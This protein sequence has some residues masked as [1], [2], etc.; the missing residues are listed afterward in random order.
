MARELTR[1]QVL[2]LLAWGLASA[3]TKRAGAPVFEPNLRGRADQR[4]QIQ[5]AIDRCAASGG[6][7]VQLPAA[8]L[9]VSAEQYLKADGTVGGARSLALRSGVQLRGR[10]EKTVIRVAPHAY[11]P[12]ALF[13][14]IGNAESEPLESASVADLTLDGARTQQVANRQAGNIMLECKSHVT[15]ERVVSL[16]ANGTSI[17][18]RGTPERRAA[19]LAVR[20]CKVHFASYIGIQMSQFESGEIA[21]NEISDTDDNGI[22]I[23]GEDGSDVA[24][25]TSFAIYNNRVTRSTIGVFVETSR[26]GTVR[27]NVV[28]E[29]SVAGVAINR[30]HGEPRNIRV[31]QN[32]LAG[33]AGVRITGD[34]GGVT[35]TGNRIVGFSRA[36]V[37]LGE[38]SSNVSHVEVSRN[39][40]EPGDEAAPIVM[41]E[42]HQASFL[43]GRGNRVTS[44]TAVIPFRSTAAINAGVDLNRLLDP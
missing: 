22:D 39:D 26:D 5:E 2:Q 9:V 29:V 12:G 16:A 42:G 8:E 18:L 37:L 33:R 44:R 43:S 24:A 13:A 1:R 30:I 32:R 23:Y 36:G 14:I 41:I 34:T 21:F 11:G 28:E 31:E 20:Q 27:G 6:G 15:V 19:N 38:G 40:F 25:T 7:I 10:G 35:I 4:L 3:C 17:M